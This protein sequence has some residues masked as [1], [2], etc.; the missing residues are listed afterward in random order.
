[1]IK[2]LDEIVETNGTSGQ[3]VDKD[4]FPETPDLN[5]PPVINT[6]LSSSCD[7]ATYVECFYSRSLLN[8][9]KRLHLDK[10]Q[11]ALLTLAVFYDLNKRS[12]GPYDRTRYDTPMWDGYG[13]APGDICYGGHCFQR[14]EVNY[15]AQGMYTAA[16]GEKRQA[17]L[18][19]VYAWKGVKYFEKPSDGTLFWFDLG[20]EIYQLLAWR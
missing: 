16:S 9:S 18:V 6:T 17:G 20:Y 8:I 3:D 1:V 5:A 12:L 10:S 15:F 14:Q 13:A 4:G 11:M 19:T 7:Q 2:L